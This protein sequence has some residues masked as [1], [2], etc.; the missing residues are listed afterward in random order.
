MH[1]PAKI[2]PVNDPER[3]IESQVVEIS[4]TGMRLI[5]DAEFQV[6]QIFTIET[7]QHLILA[8][9]R[10]CLARGTRFVIGAERIHSA[11]KLALP[12]YT[13]KV[14]RNH[15]L[16]EDLQRRLRNERQGAPEQVDARTGTAVE[17]FQAG[18]T[19]SGSELAPAAPLPGVPEAASP[20][21]EIPEPLEILESLE[22]L[23][24]LQ[25]DTTMAAEP[26]PPAG[27]M[28]R[29][30]AP[31][32]SSAIRLDSQK[33]LP[34]QAI[35]VT[36]SSDLHPIQP[37]FE[38]PEPVAELAAAQDSGRSAEGVEPENPAVPSIS[39]PADEDPIR[40]EAKRAAQ[41]RLAAAPDHSLARSR[42]K[43]V[44]V[45]VAL[46]VVALLAL[47]MGFFAKRVAPQTA[48]ATAERSTAPVSAPVPA[49]VDMHAS[50]P[51]S[52]AAARPATPQL[53]AAAQPARTVAP[54][55]GKSR[56]S[57]TASDRSWV[58][59][60]ADGKMVFSKLFTSGSKED[61][62]FSG[63]AVVRTGSAGALEMQL[64]GKPTGPLGRPGQV[65]VIEFTPDSSRFISPG[66]PDDCTR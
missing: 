42:V 63:R 8:E 1:A 52:A 12:A 2:A 47:R 27:A 10:N 21:A 17:R 36:V 65:R 41:R 55:A 60:C 25:E 54:A 18:R 37:V 48:T 59:A 22:I 30:I 44:F 51:V 6:D 19:A 7:D 38:T 66:E 5:A 29:R 4:G 28:V 32:R 16:I 43:A 31:L 61:V 26:P 49:P 3:E 53:P 57:I 20:V 9:V 39:L 45:A 33:D 62:A 34:F 35:P 11:A 64:N 24:P 13:S 15:A 50:P 23:E 14:E 40:A 46:T 58:T 56:V